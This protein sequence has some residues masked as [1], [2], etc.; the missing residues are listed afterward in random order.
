MSD[1]TLFKE[2]GT[3]T[4]VEDKST[5][6]GTQNK[7]DLPEAVK[8]LVGEGRKYANLEE[9]AK[10]Y[11]HIDGFAEKLKSENHEMREALAKAKTFD[12]VL[13]AI[14]AGSSR[15]ETDTSSKSPSGLSA[16]DVAKIVSTTLAQNK[17]QEQRDANL[18]AADA[19]LRQAFGSKA[20]EVF[21]READ[22]PEKR[23]ALTQLAAVDPAKFVALFTPAA[24]EQGVSLDF[25]TK[26][27]SGALANGAASGRV[28][29]KECKEYYSALRVKDP[30]AYYSQAV[31]LQMNKA[32]TQNPNKFF[33]N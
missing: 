25:T 20:Q 14:K 18:K 33:G 9:L 3:E 13:V 10:A 16:A 5:A 8:M 17:T 32:A 29:D 15:E 24:K 21:E 31:Q 28:E 12:D 30:K 11:V 2:Q 27:N 4:K 26:V 6:V 22:T 7:D 19:A 1:Q 23:A